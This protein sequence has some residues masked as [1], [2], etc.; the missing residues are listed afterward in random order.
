M[1]SAK[2]TTEA[3]DLADG[4]ETLLR[5]AGL[6]TLADLA[7]TILRADPERLSVTPLRR[8][9]QAE[10]RLT[11]AKEQYDRVAMCSHD[12]GELPTWALHPNADQGKRALEAIGDLGRSHPLY[13]RV[14]RVFR[15]LEAVQKA[16]K[17]FERQL[18]S[19][20]QDA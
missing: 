6:A 18:A 3:D 12:L 13:R 5:A 1:R 4:F 11:C 19:A 7:P 16:R 10:A 9:V 15:N 2:K 8:L 14:T 17:V 20:L